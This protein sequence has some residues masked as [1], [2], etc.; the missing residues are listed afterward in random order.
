[1][2][3][4]TKLL[5]IVM[6]MLSMLSCTSCEPKADVIDSAPGPITW[7][8]CSQQI[9]DHPCDFTLPDQHGEP[10]SLYNAY[11]SIVVL[12][13]SAAWCTYCQ[14]AGSTTQTLQDAYAED[15][16]YVTVLVDDLYGAP[17]T[18]E[19]AAEWADM[20]GITAP[21]LVGSRDMLDASGLEGWPVSGWPRFFFIDK[22]MTL[23]HSLAGYSE[24]SMITVLDTMLIKEIESQ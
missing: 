8:T 4:T 23:V 17:A 1:M 9:N 12:D 18:V 14:L 16:V 19:V 5:S 11:G 7:D 13:F 24:E 15:V 22:E 10:W 2:R 21:V 20:Y 3:S 6:L